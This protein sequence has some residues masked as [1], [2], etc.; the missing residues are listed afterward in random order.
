MKICQ[1]CHG[2]GYLR[3]IVLKPSLWCADHKDID[4]ETIEIEQCDQCKSEGEVPD[5]QL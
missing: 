2:N 4:I 3:K 5:A 1:V